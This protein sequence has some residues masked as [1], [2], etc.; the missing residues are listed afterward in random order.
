MVGKNTLPTWLIEFL[1]DSATG[2]SR[3]QVPGEA[4]AVAAPYASSTANDF[5]A[6]I[7][8]PWSIEEG[9]A[10][11]AALTAND[12]ELLRDALEFDDEPIMVSPVARQAPSASATLASSLNLPDPA[13]QTGGWINA[14]LAAN[15]PGKKLSIRDRDFNNTFRSV[16][17]KNS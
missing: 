10:I 14:A 4:P 7:E 6:E 12:R 16:R 3:T 13:P 11:M 17:P 8:A 1:E 9:E 5:E 2:T 15:V